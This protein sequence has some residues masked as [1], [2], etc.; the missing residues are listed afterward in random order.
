MDEG[1]LVYIPFPSPKPL[2]HLL[3]Q[4]KEG[5]PTSTSCIAQWPIACPREA[6]QVEHQLFPATG[7]RRIM[8]NGHR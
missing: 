2:R 8:A 1:S 5:S 3:V 4:T 7:I 6:I